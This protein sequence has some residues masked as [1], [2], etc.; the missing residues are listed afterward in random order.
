[1]RFFGITVFRDF[2][3]I[4]E[5]IVV[6]FLLYFAILVSMNVRPVLW[7]VHSYNVFSI[8]ISDLDE[9]MYYHMPIFCWHTCS[10]LETVQFSHSMVPT[11]L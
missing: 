5:S 6:Y 1:M 9:I 10:F 3:G 8:G 7:T 4:N 11:V 2:L